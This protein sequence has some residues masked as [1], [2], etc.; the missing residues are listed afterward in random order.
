[1]CA[2]AALGARGSDRPEAT[3]PILVPLGLARRLGLWDTNAWPPPPPPSA[4]PPPV[5]PTSPTCET[6][7]A[8]RRGSAGALVRELFDLAGIQ[9]GGPGPGDIQVHN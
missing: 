9:I 8:R 3:A 4:P 6:R 1:R 5:E 7:P 2:G